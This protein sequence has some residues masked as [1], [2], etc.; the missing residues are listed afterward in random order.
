MCRKLPLQERVTIIAIIG[1]CILFLGI[2][3]GVKKLMVWHDKDV[4]GN[5]NENTLLAAVNEANGNLSAT[6]TEILKTFAELEN[7]DN[8][9]FSYVSK[10]TTYIYQITFQ[11]LAFIAYSMLL[12][13]ARKGN[14]Y[15]LLPFLFINT[16]YMIS[17]TIIILFIS[18]LVFT[19]HPIAFLPL[20]CLVLTLRLLFWMQTTVNQLCKQLDSEAITS[21]QVFSPSRQV[22]IPI[23]VEMNVAGHVPVNESIRPL[24]ELQSAPKYVAC[25][26]IE[27]QPPSYDDAVRPRA[28]ENVNLAP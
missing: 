28:V 4:N 1:L 6:G 20:L 27:D 19:L 25:P 23:D 22:V 11:T 10:K 8:W 15:L 26:A 18:Y 7:K 21:N 2:L 16:L 12:I 5:K 13:G 17:T 24:T 9:N 14:K 3:G